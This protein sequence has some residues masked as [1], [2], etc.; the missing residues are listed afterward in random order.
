MI[1]GRGPSVPGSVKL[2]GI[3]PSGSAAEPNVAAHVIG[4]VCETDL[5]LGSYQ[6]D[7]TD[8]QCHRSLLISEHMLDCRTHRGLTGVGSPG[9]LCHRTA[10]RLLA[11]NA[12]DQPSFCQQCFVLR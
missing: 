9:A 1:G 12:R 10:A 11:M 8:H 6:A 7:S 3:M 4:K 2:G 5:H